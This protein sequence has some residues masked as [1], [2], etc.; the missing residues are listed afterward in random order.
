[1]KQSPFPILGFELTENCSKILDL[2]AI[3][4]EKKGISPHD[5]QALSEYIFNGAI[6]Y[7]GYGEQRSIYSRSDAFKGKHGPRDI[8]LGLDIW[9][10]NGS[11]IYAP[12]D[13][14]ICTATDNQ[15]LGNYG[16]TVIVE[17][18][19][20]NERIFILYGHLDRKCL[21]SK[22]KGDHLEAGSTIGKMGAK[23]ENGNWPPHVHIQIIRD[24][25][26]SSGDYPGACS[27][28]DWNKYAEN[29]PD[30]SPY[31]IGESADTSP[32]IHP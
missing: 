19:I 24:L 6:R 22:R 11:E 4:L 31:F 7:G 14:I 5:N 21:K 30:P 9:C 1:M 26:E 17:H 3:T 8:H 29:C 10:E 12:W 32:S 28:S 27:L 23:E 20:G 16:P 15:G 13:G 25:G 18:E 2:S